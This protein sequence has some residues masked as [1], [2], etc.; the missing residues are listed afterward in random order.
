MR[1][2]AA[3]LALLTLGL[4][5]SLLL[6]AADAAALDLLTLGLAASRLL[7][8]AEAAADLLTLGLAASLLLAAADVPP[9]LEP[10]RT[11]DLDDLA[12]EAAL[13][14]LTLGLA[15][16]RLLAAA[17]L[18]LALALAAD[19]ALLE[20][21]PLFAREVDLFPDLELVLPL[22]GIMLLLI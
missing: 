13:D 8:A 16:S 20:P 21:A 17:A 14:L 22:G 1:L 5:A 3:V 18:D 2:A 19:L 11:P 9:V 7:A 15:A 6:A 10:V 12:V 4:F